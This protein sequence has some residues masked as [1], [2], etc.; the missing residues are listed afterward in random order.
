MT[1]APIIY[2][3]LIRTSVKERIRPLWG[4]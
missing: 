2:Y 3:C 4:F 1:L